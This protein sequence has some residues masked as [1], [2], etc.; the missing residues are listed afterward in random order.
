M[1]SVA[2]LAAAVQA[3]DLSWSQ[4]PPLPDAEGVAGPFVGTHNGALIVAGGANFPGAK[5]WMG[6]AK[7]WHS[8]IHVLTPSAGGELSWQPEGFGLLRPLAYGASVT[9]DNGIICIGGC[10]SKQAYADVFRL[11]WNSEERRI[12]QV[13]LPSLPE[14][15]SNMGAGRVGRHIY[16]VAGKN[17]QGDT[18]TFLALNLDH[19]ES[20]W[21][22]LP[23][24]PGIARAMPVVA[25]HRVGEEDQLFVISGRSSGP[26]HTL[27]FFTDAWVYRPTDREWRRLCD[28]MGNQRDGTSGVPAV[29]APAA[30]VD[31][32]IL[33]FGGGGSD[34]CSVKHRVAN[35][36]RIETIKA[37]AAAGRIGASAAEKRIEGLLEENQMRMALDAGHREEVFEYDATADRWQVAGRIPHGLS[38]LAT[39]A[40]PFAGGVVIPSGETR[41]GVRTPA[42][43]LVRTKGKKAV[44][45]AARPNILF[46]VCD[47]M[48]D[49]V[50]FL[51]GHPDTQTPNMDRL[52]KRGM[53]FTRAYCASPIC[54][55][56]RAAVL[57]GLKPETSGV[58]NNK[59]TYVDYVPDAVSL[60]RFFKDN[61]YLV[62][63]AG[64]IN[65]AMGVVVRENWHEFGPDAGAIGGPFT[66]EELNMNPGKKVER[67][68]IAGMGKSVPSGIVKNVYPGKV[69]ERGPL[70]AT[71]PLNGIDN[72]IDRPAN[73]YNTF[74]WGGLDIPDEMMP[75]GRMATWAERKLRE[76]YTSPFFLAVGFYRPHQPWY[77][78]SKYF[79]PFEGRALALPPTVLRDLDDCGEAA[80][81]YAHYPW[82]GS[83]ATVQKYNQ[84]QD[85]IRGYL[86]SIHFA[87]AQVGRLLDALDESPYADNTII[88]LWSD[89]GWE[90]G[91][92]EHWGK[93]SPWEGSM[94][95]PLVIVPPKNMQ[96]PAGRSE[97]FASL[98]DLYPTLADL[99]GFEVPAELE[100]ESLKS[101]ISGESDAVRD[102]IVTTLGRATFSVR[103]EDWKYIHYYDGSEELYDLSSD[104]NEFENLAHNAVHA[105]ALEQM[106]AL[107]PEDKRFRQMVRCG[108]YKGILGADGQLKVYDML[109]PKSGIGEHTEVSAEQSEIV[110]RIKAWMTANPGK[111]HRMLEDKE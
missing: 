83:F 108:Q 25:A 52:A 51:G 87:D 86:A 7:V 89:H 15:L 75:D 80:R 18:Q 17:A 92:K 4:L 68:D 69:I 79:K 88:V 40:L 105:S 82:S 5:P 24:F 63:G 110:E 28:V 102:H 104:P 91:E 99:C 90:L 70:Q 1:L 19:P 60:P 49:W 111:R 20:G 103:K 71:L 33:V 58:Y 106:R 12:E 96:S 76:Q 61:G 39:K 107:V 26:L 98:L 42:L 21:Q 44:A 36:A 56:S 78:P 27:E 64:K 30:S 43:S 38:T 67:K 77:A 8:R 34:R 57:T 65:H 45:S 84:W 11:S 93:H 31:G 22:A 2:L 3:V 32:R 85:A 73:G 53:V 37:D 59:G 6:G 109:H 9:T 47:D 46:I 29:A 94:R 14:P 35:A 16:V 48:N 101:V 74:D 41:P 10:D 13:S 50:G 23:P 72:L 100:G 55:P 66:W 62:M 97:G 95:V 81:Q 54:G